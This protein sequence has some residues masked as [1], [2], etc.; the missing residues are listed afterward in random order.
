MPNLSSGT[1][2]IIF[3]TN[4]LWAGFLSFFLLCGLGPSIYCL[5]PKAIR[6]IRHSP[7]NIWILATPKNIPINN[8]SLTLRISPK[9]KRNDIQFCDES[10]SS[11]CT[12]IFIFLKTLKTL[13]PKNGSSLRIYENIRV[14]QGTNFACM[15]ACL[16][17][18]TKV[19][20]CIHVPGVHV[21]FIL[22]IQLSA[23]MTMKAG[24]WLQPQKL[25]LPA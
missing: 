10:T 22:H 17:H 20:C 2:Q 19:G 5:P 7:K 4:H 14:P 3:S 18:L 11:S 24:W 21:S 16:Q 13:T 25:I 6:N 8:N 1:F 23:T 15:H 12:M 9:I